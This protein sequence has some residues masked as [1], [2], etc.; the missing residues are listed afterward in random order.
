MTATRFTVML[1]E[2]P[3]AHRATL[4]AAADVVR[5]FPPAAG[6]E[7]VIHERDRA[8][9]FATRARFRLAGGR[10]REVKP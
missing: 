5:K 4:E 3:V 7:A 2:F 10:V 9:P 6:R 1:G 8:Y